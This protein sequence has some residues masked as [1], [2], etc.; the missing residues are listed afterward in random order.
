MRGLYA[1]DS[2]AMAPRVLLLLPTST[3]RTHDFMVA[4]ERLGAKIVVASEKTS[5][6]ERIAEDSL[7][8]LDFLDPLSSALKVEKFHARNPLDA[9]VSVDEETAVVAAAISER[10]G[11]EG[12]APDAARKAR[13]KHEMRVALRSS[14]VPS[15]QFRLCTIE[16]DPK[17][18]ASGLDFPVVLKPV[19][20]SG[21][22]GVQ[23]VNDENGFIKAFDWTKKFLAK[24]ELVIRGGS[25]SQFILIETFISGS[26]VAVEA[27]LSKGKLSTL[28]IFDKPDPL[29]G[30]YFEE[31]IYVTPSRW[32][33]QT[34]SLIEAVT[35]KA[36]EALGLKHGP[37]HAEIR[38]G[39]E[40]PCVIEIAGRSVGGLCSRT[41]R[42]G[43]GLSLEEIILQHALGRAVDSITLESEA[44]GVMMIPT[45]R[46][47]VLKKVSGVVEAKSISYIEDVTISAYIGEK[48]IPIPEGSRYLGFIFARAHTAELVESAIRK[49][50]RKLMFTIE[51]Q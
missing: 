49:A 36:A 6:L 32:D 39:S 40:G 11:V 9:V 16:D 12:N 20:L 34:V 10:I 15:P 19:F 24:P 23:R 25:Y 2:T 21:S 37:V 5:S 41:L 18:I 48:L 4:A 45:P 51:S 17:V 8:T 13:L 1:L 42:F 46:A 43:L 26:E 22:R 7:L 30:P 3:Y 35:L 50:H 47:G 14:G 38:L 28:A 29:E 31:T 27:L 44:S 33:E